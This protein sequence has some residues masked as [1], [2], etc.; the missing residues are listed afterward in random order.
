MLHYDFANDSDFFPR[1]K[2]DVSSLLL[3]VKA[4]KAHR[5]KKIEMV[6]GFCSYFTNSQ[7]R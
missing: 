3:H 1:E 4:G 5:V 6:G 7:T 2:E